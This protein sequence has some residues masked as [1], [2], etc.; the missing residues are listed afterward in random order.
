MKNIFCKNSP[1][2]TALYEPYVST[3]GKQDSTLS[4]VPQ[5]QAGG[6][7]K[8]KQTF[9][10]QLGRTQLFYYSSFINSYNF[11]AVFQFLIDNF[12]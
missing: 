4:Q 6:A 8:R 2:G 7:A 9:Y 1:A 12:E 10:A 3:Y 5:G 11:F